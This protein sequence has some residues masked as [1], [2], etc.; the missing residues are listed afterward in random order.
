MKYYVFIIL[1]SCSVA[2]AD[3][4]PTSITARACVD[5][6]HKQPNGVFAIYVFCDDALGTNVSIFLKKLGAPLSGK[7]ALGKRFWQDK[8][9]SN[10]VTSYVWLKDKRYLLLATSGIYGS[11]SL[12]LLNLEEQTS[13]VLY[14]DT[15]ASLE[16]TSIK[17]DFVTLRYETTIGNYEQKIVQINI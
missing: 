17:G 14:Q 12:Y 8:E 9:W 5:G 2:F 7:Y 16:I 10:D 6:T 3:N 4:T 1:F 11:G 15:S 13:T